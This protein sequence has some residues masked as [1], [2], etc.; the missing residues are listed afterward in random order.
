MSTKEEVL[1]ISRKQKSCFIVCKYIIHWPLV[2]RFQK[3][4]DDPAISFLA[5]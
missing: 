3:S 4:K 5:I 2:P 1:D